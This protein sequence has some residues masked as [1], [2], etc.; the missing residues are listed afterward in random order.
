LIDTVG[1]TS[2]IES[3]NALTNALTGGIYF[4]DAITNDIQFMS[5]LDLHN[6]QGITIGVTCTKVINTDSLGLINPILKLIVEI[7]R[8]KVQV[9]FKEGDV[10]IIKSNYQT[11]STVLTVAD[12]ILLNG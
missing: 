2:L 9:V 7:D 6:S 11:I 10:L 5:G 8:T 3:S 1:S 4:D 12:V